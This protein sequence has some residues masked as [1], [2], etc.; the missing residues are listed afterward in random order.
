MPF[1]IVEL[2]EIILPKIESTYYGPPKIDVAL[3]K[4]DTSFWRKTFPQKPIPTLM[5]DE[6]ITSEVGDDVILV[7]YP[8]PHFLIAQDTGEPNALEPIVQFGRIAGILPS[9]N[10]P[11][12]HLLAFDIFGTYGS[13]GSPVIRTTDFRVIGIANEMLLN[14]WKKTV[15]EK[16]LKDTESQENAEIKKEIIDFI[17]TGITYAV[18][19]NLFAGCLNDPE[20]PGEFKIKSRWDK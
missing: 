19:S 13:S 14:R 20:N 12:P 11:L 4:I 3:L 17:P 8:S 7:G 9:S 1:P 15:T 16:I 6:S 5:V 2:I 18:P 10:A